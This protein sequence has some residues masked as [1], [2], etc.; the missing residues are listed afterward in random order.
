MS[1]I[2][3]CQHFG[4]HCNAYVPFRSSILKQS[5]PDD[6]DYRMILIS[7]NLYLTR[8]HNISVTNQFHIIFK[9][10]TIHNIQNIGMYIYISGISLYKHIFL[11]SV[12]APHI[13]GGIQIPFYVDYLYNMTNN[14]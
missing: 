11:S 4:L 10:S 3:L 6:I 1:K 8:G 9:I 12:Q 2:N 7:T 13:C 14:L 5:L